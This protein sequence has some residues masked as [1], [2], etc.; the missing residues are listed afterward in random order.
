MKL[1]TEASAL[2]ILLL[3]FLFVDEVSHRFCAFEADDSGNAFGDYSC[4]WIQL[5][6]AFNRDRC[7]SQFFEYPHD[8]LLCSI[9]ITAPDR[10]P[11]FLD[12]MRLNCTAPEGL[13]II[14]A[15]FA[16]EIPDYLPSW[17]A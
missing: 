6:G 9:E 7:S 16:V 1:P 10:N 3:F 4:I 8:S 15:A 5:L 11:L 2:L 13:C 17:S 12:P 14:N